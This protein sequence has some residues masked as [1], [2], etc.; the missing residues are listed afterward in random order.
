MAIEKTFV[1]EGVKESEVESFLKREFKRTGY[2][3]TEI[4]RTPVGT[5]IVVYANKPGL[6]IGRSG[7]RVNEI[8]EEIKKK[9]DFENLM[10]DVR[11]VRDPMLDANIVSDRV[12]AALERGIN[13]KRV[14][15][16][17]LDKVT[18]AGAVGI[19]IN[20]AGKLAGAERSRYQKFHKGFVAHSGDYSERLV[21][22]GY[23]QAMLK[24]GIVGIQ[25]KIMRQMPREVE[26]KLEERAEEKTEEKVVEAEGKAGEVEGKEGEVKEAAEAKIKPEEVGE[27]IETGKE[28]EKAVEVEIE[29]EKKVKIEEKIVEAGDESE[30]SVGEKKPAKKARK[31][32]SKKTDSVKQESKG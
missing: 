23:A 21:D 15:N 12:A 10:I 27:A 11:E 29:P 25:V 17:Y 4:H 14:C 20:V 6:V 19:Q 31:R 3:H 16:F 28:V 24:P 2:S 9:F 18:E 32:R 13:Y 5:R 8:T 1:K 26:K 7:R 30:E 22:K